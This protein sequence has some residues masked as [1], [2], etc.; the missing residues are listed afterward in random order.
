VDRTQLVDLDNAVHDVG[1]IGGAENGK[2]PV[3][4]L[5]YLVHGH[6]GVPHSGLFRGIHERLVVLFHDVKLAKALALLEHP[7]HLDGAAGTV[8]LLVH[9]RH[10]AGKPG[11]VGIC[12]HGHPVSA[13][14]D[15]L[16]QPEHIGHSFICHP[17]HGIY[18]LCCCI[19]I[20]SPLSRPVLR[21]AFSF[22]RLTAAATEPLRSAISLQRSRSWYSGFS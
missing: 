17:K 22:S 4:R 7:F 15:F 16:D 2:Q 19:D 10:D 3:S 14:C 18:C 20:S 5:I 13:L 1:L 21:T 9:R 12:C 11:V 8:V 6:A